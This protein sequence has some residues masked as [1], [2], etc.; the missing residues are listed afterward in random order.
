MTELKQTTKVT[1]FQELEFENISLQEE[2]QRLRG[3]LEHNNQVN[4]QNKQ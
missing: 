1:K 4:L 2:L 3:L